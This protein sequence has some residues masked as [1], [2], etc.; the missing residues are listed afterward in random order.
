MFMTASELSQMVDIRP[1]SG[2]FVFS[3]SEHYIEGEENEE[4]KECLENWLHHFGIELTQI[5][6][7]G[8]ADEAGVRKMIDGIGAD[9]VIPVHTENPDKFK[10]MAG[11]VLLPG[12]EICI[13]I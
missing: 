8:H 3:M 2:T 1:K 11:K 10:N 5:H 7:S 4:Y 9:I 13:K 12:K 6:C